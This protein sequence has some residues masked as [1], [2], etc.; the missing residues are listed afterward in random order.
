MKL[1]IVILSSN[2]PVH[3]NE[4]GV[5]Y[6]KLAADNGHPIASYM[7]G[8]FLKKGFQIKI[9][10][11][12]SEKYLIFAADNGNVDAQFELALE[13]YLG[14]SLS[15]NHT[16]SLHYFCLDAENKNK[17]ACETPGSF[18]MDEIG[19]DHIN[20]KATQ[21]LKLGS[22][23]GSVLCKYRLSLCYDSSQPDESQTLLKQA[24]DLGYAQA[25]LDYGLLLLE[26]EN[27]KKEAENYFKNGV[28]SKPSNC[29]L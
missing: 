21:Y 6:I 22:D 8:M 2:A 18:Y 12:Q 9:D 19:C 29:T 7:Y 4:K 10:L 3:N 14:K 11:P 23:L 20:D 16:K 5:Y 25:K 13:Y 26:R 28:S 15:Q 24:A 1:E 27:N 17:I